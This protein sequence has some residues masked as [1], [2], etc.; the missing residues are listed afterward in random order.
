M[1]ERDPIKQAYDAL[2]HGAH[3]VAALS[4]KCDALE[5]RSPRLVADLI[6]AFVIFLEHQMPT[7]DNNNAMGIVS[8]SR[9]DE[10]IETRAESGGESFLGWQRYCL[11]LVRSRAPRGGGVFDERGCTEK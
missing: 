10:L 5:M 7:A 6:V 4:R 1:A 8:L 2:A 9:A 11:P 3:L